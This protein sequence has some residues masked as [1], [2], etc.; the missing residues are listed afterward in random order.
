MPKTGVGVRRQ[1]AGGRAKGDEDDGATK[2]LRDLET[3]ELRD[4]DGKQAQSSGHGA[5]GEEK[6][7][8]PWF[9]T[10]DKRKKIK[11][12]NQAEKQYSQIT[13]NRLQDRRTARLQ[14]FT[15]AKV[16]NGLATR[17]PWKSTCLVKA[18]AAS[19][20]LSKRHIPHSIHFGMK[21]NDSGNYEAHAWVSAGGRVL[22]GGENV[23]EFKEVGRFE[24]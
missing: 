1:A 22:I 7:K 15:I 11:V 8:D 16:V 20:M 19:K 24:G 13:N 4:E 17:T 14:D 23:E 12:E 2:G 5:Q 3:K 9:K 10:K 6:T 21:K 18:L